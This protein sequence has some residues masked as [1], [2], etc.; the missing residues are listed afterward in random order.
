MAKTFADQASRHIAESARKAAQ[1]KSS[2]TSAVEDGL[3]AAKQAAQ[4][5]REAVEE[6]VDDTAKRVKR[7][8]I[9]SVLIALAIGV[10][11]GFLIGRSTKD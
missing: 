9:E 11:L 2:V 8:P 4:D 1:F 7:R 5:G 10:S 6:F 3:D